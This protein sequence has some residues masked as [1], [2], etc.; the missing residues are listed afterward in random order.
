MAKEKRYDE[1][2]LHV[3][4]NSQRLDANESIFFA[5]ELES[6]KARTYDIQYAELSAMGIIPVDGSAGSGAETIAYHQYDA[7]GQAKI[8][9]NY[10]TDLPRVDL[11]GKKFTADVKSIGVSYGY[12]VQDI[13]AARMA[14]KPLEQRKASA[15]RRAND[16]IVND[17]AFNGDDEHGLVGLLT[18]PNIPTYTLPADGTGSSTKFADKTADQVLRDL[19]GMVTK[20]LELTKNVERP[21]TLLIGHTTHADIS[22]RRVGDTQVTILAFF[23]ANNPYVKNVQVVPEFVGAGTGGT[24]ICMVY[25]KSP[26]KL[27]LEI[28]QP[29]EQFPVQSEKLEY[30]VNCHSR[31]AGVIIYYPLSLIKAEGC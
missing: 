13:R 22:S 14:G 21:D 28:P 19:N 26:D 12:S 23:L 6:V 29:F 27:T 16:Q 30:I 9:A 1:R 11:V 3:I 4:E 18:H 25:K 5:Q 20:M 10:S 31:C 15:A 17:I 2:D 7:V 8:I 24:D